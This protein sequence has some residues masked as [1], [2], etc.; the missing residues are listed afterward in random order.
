MRFG[1]STDP[2]YLI[3]EDEGALHTGRVLALVREG[4]RTSIVTEESGESTTSVFTPRTIDRR[5]REFWK[6]HAWRGRS[7]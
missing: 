7:N 4:D 5:S 3:L 1:R 2:I 6:K